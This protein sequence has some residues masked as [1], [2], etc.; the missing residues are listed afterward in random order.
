[1]LAH[2]DALV[3]EAWRNRRGFFF[4]LVQQGEELFNGG[5][6]DVSAVVPCEKGLPI[7]EQAMPAI[8]H[9]ETTGAHIRAVWGMRT[10]PFKSRKKIAEAILKNNYPG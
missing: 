7:V 6:G 4:G 5:H 10:L 8:S 9:G 3:G 2:I 1:M